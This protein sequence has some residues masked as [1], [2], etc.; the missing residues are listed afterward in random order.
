VVRGRRTRPASSDAGL[1]LPVAT[2]GRGRRP[3]R[4]PGGRAH[5]TGRPPPRL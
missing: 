3:N 5:R 4:A 1:T 2:R